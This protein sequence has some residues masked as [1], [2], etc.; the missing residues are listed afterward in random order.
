MTDCI[1]MT[2]IYSLTTERSRFTVQAFASG[3]LSGFVHNPIF[4]IRRFTGLVRFT[5]DAPDLSCE[6]N[7]Q[8]NSLTLT[9]SV[10]E[11]DRQDIERRMF[12]EVLEAARFPQIV[13]RSTG[14]VLTQITENWFRA[15]VDGEMQ[16][17]G[18]TKPQ[19]ID[20]QVRISD[21]ELRLGG[22]LSLSLTAHKLKRIT[23]LGGLIQLK[24]ELKFAFDLVGQKQ[25]PAP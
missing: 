12:D 10:K 7:V 18:I 14:S 21:N 24:D 25:E 20:M 23:A 6:I 17:H 3:I 19:Q 15:Q 5:P 8:A 16:L 9:G 1:L 2:D 4:S 22:E 13:F 11:E